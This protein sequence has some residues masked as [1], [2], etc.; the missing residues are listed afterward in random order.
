MEALVYNLDRLLDIMTYQ[1]RPEAP[2]G[3]AP[4]SLHH[5]LQPV[6]AQTGCQEERLW[7]RLELEL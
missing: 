7:R 6:L 2:Q 1:V 4:L 3:L 5:Q